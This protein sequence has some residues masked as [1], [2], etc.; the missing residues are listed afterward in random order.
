MSLS[1]ESPHLTSEG[2]VQGQKAFE[3]SRA[4]VESLLGSPVSFVRAVPRLHQGWE[5]DGWLWLVQANDRKFVV[6]TDHGRPYE[7][8]RDELEDDA[9]NY[10]RA[11]LSTRELLDLT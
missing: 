2:L 7:L 11:M 3:H 10:E 5:L 9:Q 8:T 4:K 1:P 6:G